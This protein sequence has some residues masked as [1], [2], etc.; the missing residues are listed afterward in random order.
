M[1]VSVLLSVF[2]LPLVGAIADRTAH[3]KQL[4][5]AFAFIG[6]ALTCSFGLVTG[7]GYA[8]CAPANAAPA[9]P[10]AA[11]PAAAAITAAM[12]VVCCPPDCARIAALLF[13]SAAG[14]LQPANSANAALTIDSS[15]TIAIPPV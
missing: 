6:A 14:S 3:R 7:T 11:P 12:L 2:A 15:S 9:P 8:S 13:S 5:A 1:A 10:A 4:L